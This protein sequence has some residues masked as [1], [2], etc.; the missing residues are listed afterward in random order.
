MALGKFMLPQGM[1]VS[2]TIAQIKREAGITNFLNGYGVSKYGSFRGGVA[3][4]TPTKV[5]TS[6]QISRAQEAAKKEIMNSKELTNSMKQRI[7]LTSKLTDAQKVEILTQTGV[8]EAQAKYL[9]GLKGIRRQLL[10][11]RLAVRG[12]VAS[13]AAMLPQMGIFAAIA[14]ITALHEKT[15]QMEADAADFANTIRDNAKTDAAG[16]RESVEQYDDL[17]RLGTSNMSLMI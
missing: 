13:I 3:G 16:I 5:N 11:A 1:A 6:A 8:A 9:V 17:Y 4:Y 15:K 7:A 10:L 14:A 2:K 12:F